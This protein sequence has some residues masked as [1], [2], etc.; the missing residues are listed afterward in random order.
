MAENA[1]SNNIDSEDKKDLADFGVGEVFNTDIQDALA[2]FVTKKFNE[3]SDH[4]RRQGITDRLI[5]NLRAN[6]CEYQPDEK[7]L[8]GPY[9]DIYIGIPALKARSAESWLLD[10]IVNNIEKPWTLESTEQPDLPKRLKIQVV[11][12]LMQELNGFNSFEALKDRASQLKSAVQRVSSQ[13]AD[14][15]TDRMENLIEDQMQEGEW[16]DT[17]TKFVGN[18]VAYPTAILRGPLKVNKRV[19]Y[20]EG[21][22]FST[23]MQP[24]LKNRVVS[25][26]N[27]YPAPNASSASDGSYF[28]ERISYTQADVHKLTGVETFLESNIRQA[29]E[30]Y[31]D[32]FSHNESEDSLRDEL[33]GKADGLTNNDD[34]EIVIYNGVMQGKLLAKHGVIVSDPQA[35]YE[36]EVWVL[37]EYTIRAVLTPNPLNKRDIYSTSYRKITNSFWGQSV[38]DLTYDVGRVCNASARSVVRNMGYASGPIGEVVSERLADNDDPT[39]LKPYRIFRVAPD[40]SG[41]GAPAFKFHNVT[42]ISK[43]LMGVLEY[44]MKLADDLSGI[45]AY[46]LGQPQ[47]AGAGRTLG[48]L[49]MMMGNAAKGIKNVQLNIDRDIIHK[50]VTSY[51]YYNLQ[52]SD[53]ISIKADAKVVARGATGLLQRELSQSRTVEILQLL[54]PYAQTGL[55]DKEAIQ[56]ILRDILKNTGLD[57]DEI[58]PDPKKPEKM[59]ALSRLFARGQGTAMERGTSNPQDLPPQSQPPP[60]PPNLAPYPQPVNLAQ[61]S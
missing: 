44:Y 33:E 25:P 56:L 15:S 6:K 52:T 19:P 49:S 43:D 42:A 1:E 26:F 12:T 53:D 46:V 58:I 47:L 57:V 41:T 40:L 36:S 16:I 10:I 11:E 34:L 2:N 32:G 20:W 54:T 21:N 30:R 22:E 8:L 14:E 60:T 59:E 28:I 7:G 50:I 39:D 17:F 31:E 5:R 45:P 13:K 35:F 51:Y 23:K 24:V 61:G 38:I 18:L 29:L 27:A 4:K 37:G 9:N 3:A 48:G 55:L